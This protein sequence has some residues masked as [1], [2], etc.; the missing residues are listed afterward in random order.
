MTQAVLE[1]VAPECV[2]AVVTEFGRVVYPGDLDEARR[3]FEDHAAG[4]GASVLA[5]VDGA[6]VG[7]LTIR[8]QSHNPRFRDA[9]IPL[10]HHL[11]VFAPYQRRGIATALMDEAEARIAE[12]ATH[13]G[14]TVGL[15]DAYG[16]HKSA[17]S[18]AALA[19]SSGRRA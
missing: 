7:Y 10:I 13:A 16:A 5:R 15:F 1:W 2:D 18:P 3:H 19:P 14:I 6:L 4:G 11:A 12:R 8:W 17:A 9:G